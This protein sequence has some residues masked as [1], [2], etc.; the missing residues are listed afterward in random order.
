MGFRI[1]HDSM[2][3]IKVADEHLWGAQTQRSLENFAIGT[4]T[5]PMEV[6][7]A[8]A[9]LKSAAATANA[10]LGKLDDTK[11]KAIESACSDILNNKYPG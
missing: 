4:E 2:G 6:I 5:I 11:A 3:E 7:N 10:K 9:V 1:E 8:F